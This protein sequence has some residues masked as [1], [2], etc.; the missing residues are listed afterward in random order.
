MDIPLHDHYVRS[1]N[2]LLIF[3]YDGTLVGFKPLPE[4]ALPSKTVYR[5]LEQL[6]GDPRNTIVIISGRDPD[7]LDRVFGHL[8]L[9]MAAEHGFFVKSVGQAW[10]SNSS[11]PDGWKATVLPVLQA[12]V[13][14]HPGSHI[15][16]KTS[17][18]VWHYRQSPRNTETA[19]RRLY[20]EL[21]PKLAESGLLVVP[22]HK[23]LEVRVAGVDKGQA[24]AH[25]LAAG[26]H[27]FI[28][29]AGD[30]T[31]DEDLFAAMPPDAHTIKIG[32]SRTAAVQRLPG[33]TALIDLLKSLS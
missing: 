5:T 21:Q 31:T 14:A 33:P 30:D 12:A 20:H 18:L 23:V 9:G 28:L 22:G 11:A 1:S 16:E 8:P 4:Q 32:R 2:R 19:A 15:E 17:A 27:D 25:W 24:A 26:T 29:A 10:L 7:F 6:L 3:D 13:R